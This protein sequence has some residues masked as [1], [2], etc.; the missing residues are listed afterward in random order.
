MALRRS[1][2][3]HPTLPNRSP[4]GVEML[5]FR[6]AI[7]IEARAS[8]NLADD[9]APMSCFRILSRRKQLIDTSSQRPFVSWTGVHSN[10][11][12]HTL[13]EHLR[14]TSQPQRSTER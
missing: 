3:I 2:E 13:V 6:I 7:Q 5:R 9:I 14:N 8:Q 12:H 1:Y 10:A 4:Q 11:L